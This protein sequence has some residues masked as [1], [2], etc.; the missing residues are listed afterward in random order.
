[1]SSDIQTLLLAAVGPFVGAPIDD[2]FDTSVYYALLAVDSVASVAVHRDPEI[3]G[4]ID[5][6]VELPGGEVLTFSI[7]SPDYENDDSDVFAARIAG[8]EAKIAILE[9]ALAVQGAIG[10]ANVEGSHFR[11]NGTQVNLCNLECRVS[12]LETARAACRCHQ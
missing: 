4:K 8:L 7:T 9:A 10:Y 1:M 6:S 2:N 3:S 11:I 12:N 5:A